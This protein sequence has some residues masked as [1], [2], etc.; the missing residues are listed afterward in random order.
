MSI[1][2]IRTTFN[3]ESTSVKDTPYMIEIEF[4][5]GDGRT[6]SIAEARRAICSALCDKC[7]LLCSTFEENVSKFA[8]V[9]GNA[10]AFQSMAMLNRG[11]NAQNAVCLNTSKNT[12]VS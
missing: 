12:P 6:I 2:I 7:G 4:A 3:D 11:E 5:T 1:K 10:S 8:K 9:P